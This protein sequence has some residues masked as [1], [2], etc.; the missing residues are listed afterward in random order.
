MNVS[1]LK[2]NQPLLVAVWPGMGNVAMLAGHYLISKLGMQPVAEFS[3]AQLFDVEHVEVKDGLIRPGKRPT[4]RFYL[5]RDPEH[6]R[7]LLVFLGEGQ[8]TIGKYDFCRRLIAFAKELG[9]ERI[10]TFAS[11]A[12]QMHPSRPSRVFGAATDARA[13]AELKQLELDVLEDGHIGG[14][15]G[16]ALG[17]AVECGLSGTCLLGEIPH[18]FAQLPFPKAS[19]SV[20]ETFTL[21]TRIDLDLR[22]LAQQAAAMD[23]KLAELVAQIE[24]A[25]EELSDSSDEDQ[26]TE[27]PDEDEHQLAPLDAQRIEELF[28][29]V[30]GDRT[31]APELKRELDRLHVFADYEDRFLDLFKKSG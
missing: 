8:P 15:N 6:K 23:R 25:A 31:K 11:I 27:L 20:L 7:D 13:F 2:L 18:V 1:E 17:V 4:S 28:R 12:T 29:Q 19:L 14:L 24:T 22:E 3:A 26:E 5:W 30:R 10:F 9:V 21:M 16:L